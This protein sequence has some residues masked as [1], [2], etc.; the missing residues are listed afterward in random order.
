[1]MSI[2]SR[3]VFAVDGNGAWIALF[4]Q[5]F[6]TVFYFHVDAY[7]NNVAKD[8]QRIFTKEDMR[9]INIFE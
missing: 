6:G 2:I 8:C 5:K 1:M 4:G 7:I 3:V 9:V